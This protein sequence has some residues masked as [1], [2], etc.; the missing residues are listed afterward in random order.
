MRT[1]T[2]FCGSELSAEDLDALVPIALAHFEQ[3]HPELGVNE[4]NVRDY[5]EAEERL[6]DATERLAHIGDVEVHDANAERLDDLLQFFDRDAFA[7]NPAWAACYCM[8]H[9]IVGSGEDWTQRSAARN[10]A[11]LIARIRGGATTGLLA[12]V[13]GRPAAWVNASSRGAFPAHRGQDA[14]PDDAVG[15]IVCFIVAPPYRRHGIAARLL[16]GACAS[17]RRRGLTIAQAYPRKELRDDDGSAYHGPL[18]L[19]LD[20]GFQQT[21]EEDRYYI[22]EKALS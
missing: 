11:D 20:A 4:V 22:V 19:Y 5:L 9:H 6:S 21:A 14:H 1:T 8:C 3:Q 12:Y 2:C 13:D 18:A 16:D 17:F 7:G 15:S 10:R